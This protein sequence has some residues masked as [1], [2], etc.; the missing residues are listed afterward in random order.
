[1]ASALS[2]LTR[3][4]LL[5]HAT[6]PSSPQILPRYFSASS[7]ACARRTKTKLEEDIDM[8]ELMEYLEDPGTNDSPS[9]S[10]L[11]LQEQRIVRHYLRLIE[12]EMPHLAGTFIYF[13]YV[14]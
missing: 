9:S 3:R 11:M 1:M 8:D 14:L 7:P 4:T 12:H 10:H 2:S 6:A 5:S 13:R